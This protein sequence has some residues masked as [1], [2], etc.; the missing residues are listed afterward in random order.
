MIRHIAFDLDGVLFDGCDVHANG[1]LRAVA[2][3]R[4][5]IVLTKTYH[6]THLNG[7]PTHTKLKLLGIEGDDAEQIS[8]RKQAF[9]NN[10]IATLQPSEKNIHICETLHQLGIHI[11][12][13]SNSIRSTI[14]S[15]L[16]RM[17]IL[18]MFTGILSNQD[19]SEPKPSPMLY[20]TLYSRYNI[21]P[22][23][24]LI[25]EDSAFGIQSAT[26]SGGYVLCVRNCE[27]VTVSN[28]LQ[29]I[30]NITYNP[31]VK[32]YSVLFKK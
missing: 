6:D 16:S 23:E 1:F 4:P 29:T 3:I 24:C 26:Q 21:N 27:D 28:I 11:Y 13:V 30:E 25:L 9:T 2:H 17:G 5:D 7:L 14:E 8:I 12:C 18:H 10:H 19:V 31:S 15:I 32:R 20:R 22:D